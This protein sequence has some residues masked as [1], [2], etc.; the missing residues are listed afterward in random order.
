[1]KKKTFIAGIALFLTV[2]ALA[3]A[4]PQYDDIERVVDALENYVTLEDMLKNYEV[5]FEFIASAPHFV[6]ASKNGAVVADMTLLFGKD[7]RIRVEYIVRFNDLEIDDMIL[8]GVGEGAIVVYNG[9]KVSVIENAAYSVNGLASLNSLKFQKCEITI[10]G[11]DTAFKGVVAVDKK[12]YSY[13]KFSE[14][15]GSLQGYFTL[16]QFAQLVESVFVE[17]EE[18]ALSALSK[19]SESLESFFQNQ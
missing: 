14:E 17:A 11:G 8:S 18:A 5:S 1:M 16:I 4:A 12:R 2:T 15:F 6:L 10:D 9:E 7:Y 3:F 13:E 19:Y